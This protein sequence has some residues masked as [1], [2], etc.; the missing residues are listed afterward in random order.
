MRYDAGMLVAIPFRAARIAF[1]LVVVGVGCASGEGDEPSPNPDQVGDGSGPA[2]AVGARGSR[3]GAGQSNNEDAASDAG[4][5]AVSDAGGDA[6]SDAGRDAAS[7]AAPGEPSPSLGPVEAIHVEDTFSC[8]IRGGRDLACWGYSRQDLTYRD[9]PHHIVAAATTWPPGGPIG[10]VSDVTIGARSTCAV[11]GSPGTGGGAVACWGENTGG[12]LGNGQLTGGS[13][14][15]SVLGLNDATQVSVLGNLVAAVRANGEVVRWGGEAV[16]Y[17]V[18]SVAPTVFQDTGT[19]TLVPGM[20]SVRKVATGLW[21]ICALTF[22]GDVYC[23][24]H[25]DFVGVGAT[26]GVETALKVNLPPV[27]DLVAG[28]TE[29]CAVTNVGEVHC[30]GQRNWSDGSTIVGPAPTPRIVLG[31]SN[32]ASLAMGSYHS[33]AAHNDGSVSCW[34]YN[35]HGQLGRAPSPNGKP[36]PVAGIT[37]VVQV[38]VGSTH[39]CARNTRG[40]VY[41][42]GNRIALGNL[43]ATAPLGTP[44]LVEAL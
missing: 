32:A 19:P 9:N 4:R 39:S 3:P 28:A 35:R 34:G 27:I 6:A 33:C 38:G 44:V 15:S 7:D 37:S 2:G 1:C 29:T 42:W 5:D 13:V 14:P 10:V 31:V 23:A 12:S 41:C 40:A 18:Q 20:R 36:M 17:G 22:D 16:R 43:S 25:A 26:A 8:A 11:K 24:G 30:W 21:H